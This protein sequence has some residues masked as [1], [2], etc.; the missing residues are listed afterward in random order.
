M[1]W[2]WIGGTRAG[3]LA[4]PAT[5]EDSPSL[6][7]SLPNQLHGKLFWSAGTTDLLYQDGLLSPVFSLKWSIADV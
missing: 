7:V 2:K 4:R 6:S 1:L 5:N 3:K